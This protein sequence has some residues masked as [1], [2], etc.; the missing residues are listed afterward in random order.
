MTQPLT[1]TIGNYNYSSWSMRPWVAL[2]A[3]GVAFETRMVPLDT[4][5][6]T[7]TVKTLSPAGKVPVLLDGSFAVWDSLAIIEYLAESH[8]ALWPANAQ[9]RARA[10]SLCAQMHSGFTGLRGAMPMNIEADLP[11]HGHTPAA[12]ADSEALQALWSHELQAHGGPFLFGQ[13]SAADAYFAPVVM[14]LNTYSPPVTEQIAGYM[15]AV[16]AHPAVAQWVARAKVE[17]IYIKQDEPYRTAAQAGYP[18][19]GKVC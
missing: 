14:R 18:A 6:F 15:K 19:Q 2:T 1:L 13:W 17:H 11:G 10:R 12:L 8:P 4:P 16:T 5:V 7:S 3:A 9:R